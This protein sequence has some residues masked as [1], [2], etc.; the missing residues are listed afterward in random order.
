MKECGK[1]ALELIYGLACGFVYSD[2]A[3]IPF[4]MGKV[5]VQTKDGGRDKPGG[6]EAGCY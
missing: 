4:D 2:Y 5:M 1:N 6:K 3:L